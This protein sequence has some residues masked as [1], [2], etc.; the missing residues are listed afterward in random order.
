MASS[1]HL[2]TGASPAAVLER[3]RVR[4]CACGGCTV[5]ALL[6]LGVLLD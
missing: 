2:A 6:F 5:V 3:C 1:D 4:L